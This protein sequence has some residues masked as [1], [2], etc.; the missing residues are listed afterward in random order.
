[1]YRVKVSLAGSRRRHFHSCV[2]GSSKPTPC[3]VGGADVQSNMC[4][5]AAR[6]LL[7]WGQHPATVL[8]GVITVDVLC[9]FVLV[10]APETEN[11]NTADGRL[12]IYTE[13]YIPFALNPHLECKA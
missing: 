3:A 10:S 13:I 8:Q 12:Y 9:D 11:T 6:S 1:M 7:H 4:C 5:A 2:A